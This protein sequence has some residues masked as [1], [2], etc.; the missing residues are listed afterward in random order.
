M[1]SAPAS[2]VDHAA[3]ADAEDSA[4]ALGNAKFRPV[5]ERTEAPAV[6]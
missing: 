1:V 6:R 3:D 4:T 2:S 5:S